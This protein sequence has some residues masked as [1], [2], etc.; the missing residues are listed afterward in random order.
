[1]PG[2]CGE[3]AGVVCCCMQEPGCLG[4][5][6]SCVQ[7]SCS[8]VAN[9]HCISPILTP[10]WING[11]FE[12]CST[13]IRMGTLRHKHQPATCELLPD[14]NQWPPPPPPPPPANVLPLHARGRLL[15]W[16][17]ELCA[18]EL[19]SCNKQALNQ[20]WTYFRM[21]EGC[22]HEVQHKHAE[23]YSTARASFNE[24][25]KIYG[26]ARL[27]PHSRQTDSPCMV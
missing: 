7:M 16:C 14:I 25:D 8:P 4:G 9:R 5:G 24:A 19:L 17:G 6:E 13:S 12:G 21:G 18:N 27:L 26:L 23:V 2:G 11:V 3:S 10:K 1:M 20:S 22:P 15:G